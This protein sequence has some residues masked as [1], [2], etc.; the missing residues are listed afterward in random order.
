MF[1]NLNLWQECTKEMFESLVYTIKQING[2]GLYTV[3]CPALLPI[4]HEV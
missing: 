1:V 2:C 4:V 3:C